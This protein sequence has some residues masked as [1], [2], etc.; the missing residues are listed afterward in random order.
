MGRG[1]QSSELPSIP[2][3]Q[4]KKTTRLSFLVGVLGKEGIIIFFSPYFHRRAI[5]RSI[6][7]GWKE[8]GKAILREEEERKKVKKRE[9]EKERKGEKERKR[10]REKERKREREKERK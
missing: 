4:T 2:P 1:W 8:R 9:R 3:H 7:R 6:P 10:E 5:F